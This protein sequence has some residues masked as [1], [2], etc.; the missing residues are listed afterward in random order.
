M[1]AAVPVYVLIQ[2]N[3]A[4]GTTRGKFIFLSSR[5]LIAVSCAA[6]FFAGWLG[7]FSVCISSESSVF[8]LCNDLKNTCPKPLLYAEG[9]ISGHVKSAHGSQQFL[10]A[11]NKINIKEYATGKDFNLYFNEE[12]YVK[13]K[14]QDKCM[15]ARDDFIRFSF[16]PAQEKNYQYFFTY[17]ENIT[18]LDM[19][20]HST[21]EKIVFTAYNIRQ[22]FYR[23]ISGVFY[24]SLKYEHAALCEALI[25]GNRNN[26]SSYI[27]DNF[28]K[29]GIYHLLAISGMHISFFIIIIFALLRLIFRWFSAD[30]HRR[31]RS[32]TILLIAIILIIV[33]YN[34][35]TGTRASVMR[36][37]V[38]SAF[39]LFARH[40]RR[41]YSNKYL[42][43]ICFIILLILNPIFLSDAGFWLSFACMFAIIYTNNIYKAFFT[44]LANKL[45][46]IETGRE[47]AGK[48]SRNYFFELIVTNVSVNIFIFPLLIFLFGEFS[49]LSLPVNMAA[50]PVFYCL[51]F[52]LIVSSLAGLLWPPAGM[53]L[54]KAAEPAIII[55]LKISVQYKHADFLIIH[56][57]GF[58]VWYIFLYYLCL[59]AVLILFYKIDIR[60][61][62]TPPEPADL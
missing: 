22:R 2:N 50:V 25:L 24:K 33:L 21:A 44:L 26:L 56:S 34:F 42:L 14:T 53:M 38:M 49:F 40:L 11:I 32:G 19:K 31:A 16:I 62:K 55:L 10:F 23:C 52:V 41:D 39:V 36:A 58:S 29:S 8:K 27:S 28:R 18:T 37:S 15:F 59:G 13:A 57:A 6:L 5:V 17:G 54:I 7:N 4:H 9:R 45:K 30:E 43:S 35:I 47:N 60:L 3:R 1:L 20:G 61:K 12:V 48:S 46:K 51:L